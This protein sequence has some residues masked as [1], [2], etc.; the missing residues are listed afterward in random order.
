MKLLIA[1]IFAATAFSVSTHAAEVEEFEDFDNIVK[2]LSQ[3]TSHIEGDIG[4]DP[5]DLVKLHFSVGVI[6]NF[7]SL[8]TD[9]GPA[10]GFESGMQATLGI[11]L[12]SDN[13]LAE[14]AVRSF[15][16][17]E[18][19]NSLV[20]LREF[21]LKI[22]Y[23]MYPNRKI[24]PYLGFGVAASYLSIKESSSPTSLAPSL[25]TK[26]AKYSTPNSILL[27]GAHYRFTDALG[28]ALDFSYRAPM[29]DETIQRSSVDMTL[30]LNTTF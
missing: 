17:S 25:V 30:R 11:D 4:R 9:R 21:D 18:I 8:S 12:F 28:M 15:S 6:N 13:W 23:R 3:S 22:I 14:G 29:I 16:E 7:L 26:S 10:S 1:L 19:E 5:F 2:S 20:A 27:A 24:I